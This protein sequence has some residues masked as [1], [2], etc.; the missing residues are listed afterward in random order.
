M[1][2]R[3][4]SKKSLESLGYTVEGFQQSFRHDSTGTLLDFFKRVKAAGD[5][6][7]EVLL[8]TMG[9]E[10]GPVITKLVN[11]VGKL[12]WALGQVSDKTR[13]AGSMQ[14]EYETRSKTTANSIQLMTSCIK[15]LGIALGKFF[16]PVVRFV[17]NAI[18]AISSAIESFIQKFPTLS[19]AIAFT[20]GG[21][22]A[23]R[24]ALFAGKLG[25]NLFRS[26]IFGSIRD[27]GKLRKKLSIAKTVL[28]SFSRGAATGALKG[29]KAIGRGFLSAAKAA[30]RFTIS[31]LTNPI[32][33]IVASIA[34]AAYLIYKNWGG[35]S[36]FF[37]DMW[38]GIKE[39][40]AEGAIYILEKIQSLARAIPDSMLPD[41]MEPDSIQKTIDS[42][43]GMSEPI[44]KSVNF[45]MPGISD[46]KQ[47]FGKVTSMM[48][49][50]GE[51]ESKG[52]G[53]PS[54]LPVPSKP[55]LTALRLGEHGFLNLNKGA[56]APKPLQASHSTTINSPVTNTITIHATPGMDERD[57]A[58][59][60]GMELDKRQRQARAN[61]RAALYDRGDVTHNR[62]YL[63]CGTIGGFFSTVGG[64]FDQ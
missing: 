60:V 10:Y 8:Q 61:A 56:P 63:L 57:L 39:L 29:L 42:W 41:W 62:G 7:G 44:Y 50:G 25:T 3:P 19:K 4:R 30:W 31:L 2:R 49:F 11:N 37:S 27:L 15:A 38:T 12:E 33:W 26:A 18:G 9:Q 16:L 52:T 35:I 32:T 24:L 23:L 64:G 14:R 1:F 5:R 40:F 43:K 58:R 22:A 46:I 51:Q 54:Y 36:N 45:V 55:D 34:G 20:L 6:G 59:Q 48:G 17:S 13:Y 53:L 28:L 47:D 21:L